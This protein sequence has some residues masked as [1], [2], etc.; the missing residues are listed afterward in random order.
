MYGNSKKESSSE[1]KYLISML[2]QIL[3]K[4][5]CHHEQKILFVLFHV[6]QYKLNLLKFQKTQFNRNIQNDSMFHVKHISENSK[7]AF[8]IFNF[9]ISLN[10]S[11]KSVK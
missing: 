4:S 8:F 6:K 2:E 11:L 1:I 5:L 3:Q 7:N 9:E 10:F